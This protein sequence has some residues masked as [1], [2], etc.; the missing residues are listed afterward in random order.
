MASLERVEARLRM[1]MCMCMCVHV[2]TPCVH[3]ESL[4]D[5]ACTSDPLPPSTPQMITQ[6][7]HMVYMPTHLS[8][9]VEPDCSLE[10]R[11]T[12]LAR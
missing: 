12:H 8:I 2:C 6:R 1:C 5:C 3:A 10:E 11:E 4:T 7:T 9:L